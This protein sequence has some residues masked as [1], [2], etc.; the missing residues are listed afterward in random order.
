ML[1]HELEAY[2][3]IRKPPVVNTLAHR[4]CLT[5]RPNIQRSGYAAFDQDSLVGL[6]ILE[7]V[8]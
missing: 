5:V 8:F 4:P 6:R 3:E 7:L 1:C 2:R